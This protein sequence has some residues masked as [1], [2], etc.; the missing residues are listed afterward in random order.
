[1][2]RDR[3]EQALVGRGYVVDNECSTSGHVCFRKPSG[4]PPS[5]A[6]VFLKR[7][8]S[9]VNCGP[10]LLSAEPCPEFYSA[11]MGDYRA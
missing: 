1:M 10:T 11:L 9:M 2:S 4:F 5:R 3:L 8:G 7:D 6:V